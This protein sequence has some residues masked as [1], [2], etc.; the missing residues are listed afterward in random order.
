FYEPILLAE[1]IGTLAAFAQRPLIV[2][3]AAGGRQ[4]QFEAFGMEIE[5]RTRRLQE[6]VTVLRG[7]LAGEAVR[8]EGRYHRLDGV[9]VSPSPQKPVSLWVAGTTRAAAARAGE[10]GDAWLTSGAA[11]LEDLAVQLEAYREAAA[12]AGRPVLPVLRRD[13]YVGESDAEAEA[14]VEP[15][16]SH[17]YRGWSSGT[18][19]VGAADT[20]VQQLRDYR[21]LGFE[22]VLVRH[23]VGDHDLMLR[24]FERIGRSVLPR[25]RNL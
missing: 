7:L 22:H 10:W 12:R 21:A 24:S 15:I 17:G 3:F 8:F 5:T 20:V 25:I 1:Q 6:M 23:I 18:L 16:V 11:T 19:L 2:T 13:I 4:Q 14:A 9:M